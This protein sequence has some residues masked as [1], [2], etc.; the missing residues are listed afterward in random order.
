MYK[1][2]YYLQTNIFCILVLLLILFKLRNNTKYDILMFKKILFYSI[3]FCISDIVSITFRGTDYCYSNILLTISNTIY[4]FIPLMIGYYWINYIY[5]NIDKPSLKKKSLRYI[6]LIPVVLG[7]I[8]LV[9]N[10]FTNVLFTID[11]NNLYNRGNFFYLYAINSWIYIVISTVKTII[12]YNKSNNIFIKEK[13]FPLCLFIVAPLLTSIIQN[14]VYGLSI[15]QFGFTFSSLLVF[16]YYQ[17]EQ[18]S[19]DNLT[20]INNRMKFNEYIQNKFDNSKDSDIISLVFIDV[21]NFKEIN[22]TYGHLTGDET[23]LNISNILKKS[24]VEYD[25]NLFLARY[26]GDE[27]VIVSSLN[28]EKIKELEKVINNNL[29]IYNKE[30]HKCTSISIG[31]SSDL[32][33]NYKSVEHLID[34]ADDVM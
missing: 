29:N 17:D 15:N 7:S 1:F 33:G 20:K 22:D 10:I 27:F 25:D 16:L 12:A 24:C 5:L 19:I 23:L 21:D 3:M 13:I 28:E 8:I 9:L 6:L 2:L 26:G 14:L 34:I 18:I 30:K 32:K 4:L 11:S 31:F